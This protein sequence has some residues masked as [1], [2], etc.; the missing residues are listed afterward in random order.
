[1]YRAKHVAFLEPVG[2]RWQCTF[3]KR[4]GSDREH[5]FYWKTVHNDAHFS[6]SDLFH[7]NEE[8]ATSSDSSH[9]NMANYT[10]LLNHNPKFS[11]LERSFLLERIEKIS[12]IEIHAPPIPSRIKFPDVESVQ[13]CAYRRLVLFRQ[14]I[15]DV[16]GKDG[17]RYWSVHRNPSW[18]DG[19]MDF[20]VTASRPLAIQN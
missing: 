7:T 4:T 3:T 19:M 13:L 14:F 8:S 5:K 11:V 16:L 15:D 9:R 12:S 17:N 6:S 20:Q 1:M 10:E 2:S 18:L